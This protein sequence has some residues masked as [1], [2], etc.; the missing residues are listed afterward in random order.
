MNK[1][2]LKERYER[3]NMSM[4]Q[5]NE[6]INTVLTFEK[7][8][9]TVIENSTINDIR[10]YVKYLV[11]NKL[12]QYDN[13][14][15]IARYYYYTNMQKEYIH[16]TKYFNTSGVLENIIDRINI[17]ESEE[18]KK[19]F[20][21][22]VSLPPLGTE[23]ENLPKYT[24]EF[25]AK[26][27]KYFPKNS[28]NK[29]L[30]GNNHDIPETSLTEEVDAYDK[31]NSLNDY[32]KDRHTRKVQDL[33]NHL[34][35]NKVWFEQV[36]TQDAVDY[37]K[38]NQE[39]LSGVIENEKLYITKIPY[40]INNFLNETDD[41]LKRYYACHCSFVR[42]NILN[43]NEHIPK[44]W[45]YCS[46]GFAKFPF[47]ILLNQELDVKLLKSPIDGDFTCRFEIDLSN[48]DYKK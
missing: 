29:I 17:Y 46:A 7:H 31:S 48:I 32:L 28:C 5:I 21:N 40:E 30:A 6:S 16:M 44:E 47:E 13:F 15:H 33:Q 35:A 26:M 25:M 20:L 36:I 2:L 3:F 4:E 19:S 23:S 10:K 22:D 42:E 43:E 1:D 18:L 8:I 38:G 24:K 12:N 34:D 11:D 27:Y 45:C 9:E 14:I 41:K 39:I 37:V